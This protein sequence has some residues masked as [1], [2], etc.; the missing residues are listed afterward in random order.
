MFALYI[1]TKI[2]KTCLVYYPQKYYNNIFSSCSFT[3][4]CIKWKVWKQSPFV[5]DYRQLEIRVLVMVKV[6][7]CCDRVASQS[8]VVYT[9]FLFLLTTTFSCIPSPSQE[10]TRS[11]CERD[12]RQQC[13]CAGTKDRCLLCC[14]NGGW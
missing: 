13:Q 2:L 11:I 12:G 9:C 7:A 6:S 1:H 14:M 3:P 4:F 10:C 5:Y 8:D